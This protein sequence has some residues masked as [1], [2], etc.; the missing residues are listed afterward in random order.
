M[1][2]GCL[3]VKLVLLDRQRTHLKDFG[4]KIKVKAMK[5][6]SRRSNI[7]VSKAKTMKRGTNEFK[8]IFRIR[9][10]TLAQAQ[11]RLEAFEMEQYQGKK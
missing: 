1:N 7:F 10:S 5:K 6:L 9:F 8:C 3:K 11:L 2:E 4:Q